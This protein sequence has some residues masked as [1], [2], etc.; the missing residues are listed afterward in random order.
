MKLDNKGFTLIELL[1]VIAII[2]IL[3]SVVL[4][5]LNSARD[6]SADAA[7]KAG[8]DGLKKQIALFYDDNGG[9]YTGACVDLKIA[10]M[11]IAAQ[12][13]ILG[14]PTV[15]GLGDGDCQE[16]G[17]EWAAWVNLKASAGNAWCVDSTGKSEVVVAQD[18]T[19]PITACP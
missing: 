11:K 6:K 4:A 2:G 19:A 16:I 13:S 12:T 9:T 17:T 18:S 3:A 1:V 15:G 8:L 5:S 14:T 10:D 7:A